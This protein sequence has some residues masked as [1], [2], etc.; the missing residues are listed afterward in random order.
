MMLV[1]L[2]RKME[3]SYEFYFLVLDDISTGYIQ[4]VLW[5]LPSPWLQKN[6]A[7]NLT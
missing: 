5:K 6:I 1:K 7:P 2:K 3:M 4:Y